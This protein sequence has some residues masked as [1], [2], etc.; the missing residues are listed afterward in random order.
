MTLLDGVRTGRGVVVGVGEG[1]ARRA[2]LRD[3][4]RRAGSCHRGP[5]RRED[6]GAPHEDWLLTVGQ[7]GVIRE[8]PDLLYSPPIE[9]ML[10]KVEGE[11]IL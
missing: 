3:C 9:T 6:D 11:L 4:R 7:G 5:F 1:H 2:A 8:L 10:G